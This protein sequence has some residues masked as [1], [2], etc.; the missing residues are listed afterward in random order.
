MNFSVLLDRKKTLFFSGLIAAGLALVITKIL[1]VQYAGEGGM[2]V[3][4]LAA[5]ANAGAA[6][7]NST[8]IVQTQIDVLMSKGLVSRVAHDLNLSPTTL[9]PAVRLPKPIVDNIT[10]AMTSAKDLIH[11][12]LD[13]DVDAVKPVDPN[14]RIIDYIQKH[15]QVTAKQGSKLI[16]L[17]FLAAT[18]NVAALVV[19]EIMNDSMGSD[20]KVQADRV[21]QVNDFI[22]NQQIQM[23]KEITEAEKHLTAFVQSNNLPEVGGGGTSAALQLS[24]DEEALSVARQQLTLRQAAYNTLRKNGVEA[25]QEALESATIQGLKN[26]QAQIVQQLGTL[27][28]TDP[29]RLPLEQGLAGIRGQYAHELLLLQAAI[30]RNM[31]IAAAKVAALEDAVK[32]DM[33]R[34]QNMSNASVTLKQLQSDVENKRTA[35][36]AFQAQAGQLRSGAQQASAAHILFESVPPL[37]PAN[38]YTVLGLLL[39][40]FGG[41]TAAGGTIM[42][43]DAFGTRINTTYELENLTNL[44]TFGSLPDVK[45]LS[46]GTV[47]AAR[48]NNRS[49]VTETFRSLWITIQSSQPRTGTTLLVTSSEVGEG[50]TM[51]ASAIAQQFARDG[52]RV[53]LIDADLHRPRL[54]NMYKANPTHYIEGV[55]NN[56]VT[57]EH[58]V[59][60]PDFVRGSDEYSQGSLDC[61]LSNGQCRNPA[62]MI[63]SDSFRQ[64]LDVSKQRYDF[65]ILDSPPVLRVKDPVLLATQCDWILFVVESNRVPSNLVAEAT[66]RF[67]SKERDRMLTLLTR[68][69]PSKLDRRD[70]YG[71]YDS[72]FDETKRIG[73]N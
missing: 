16:T 45:Q 30:D 31:Q 56:L 62:K 33:A 72:T 67:P 46:N 53:L 8:S 68:V 3:E 69:K 47:V 71:G 2:V 29:R 12:V 48:K 35:F 22:E 10:T 73:F 59:C 32:S 26:Y 15:L 17:R 42:L 34:S 52:F 70:S 24:K 6:A 4:T 9:I 61:L 28:T 7:D 57:L 40:F 41:I 55:M 23:Q 1:P 25:T 13:F 18:P 14:D 37:R 19:N 20:S 38:N 44:P 58:A 64:L 49:L 43:R 51:T 65:V 39:G 11:S 5:G 36:V 27:N 63:L 54:A 66:R 21:A 50:K 60:Q